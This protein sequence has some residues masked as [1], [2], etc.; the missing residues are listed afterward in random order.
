MLHGIPSILSELL[1]GLLVGMIVLF[2]QKKVSDLRTLGI[3][4]YNFLYM[5]GF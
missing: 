4:D 3:F 2:G 1:V 5:T